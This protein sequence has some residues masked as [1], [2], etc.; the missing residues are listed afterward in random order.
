MI[1]K[2]DLMIL[3]FAYSIAFASFSSFLALNNL[4]IIPKGYTSFDSSLFG[5]III[6]SGVIGISFNPNFLYLFFLK[7]I[8]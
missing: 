8:Y 1:K 6:F 7:V 5:L 3:M 2:I 4:F